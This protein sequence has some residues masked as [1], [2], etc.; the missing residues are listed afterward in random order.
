MNLRGLCWAVDEF[1]KAHLT[2]PSEE[3]FELI[4]TTA[5]L[6][7]NVLQ[8]LRGTVLAQVNTRW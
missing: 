1:H 4:V 3:L 5:Q 8:P 2:Y 6:I 7:Q